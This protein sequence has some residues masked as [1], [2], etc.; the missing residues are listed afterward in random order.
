MI[1]SVNSSYANFTCFLM[2]ENHFI[3]AEYLVC[4]ITCILP[5]YVHLANK[6]KA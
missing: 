2:K 3:E 5:L 4:N 1:S 6:F